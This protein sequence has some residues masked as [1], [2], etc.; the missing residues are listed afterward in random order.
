MCHSERPVAIIVRLGVQTATIGPAIV[1]GAV[2]VA[3]LADAGDRDLLAVEIRNNNTMM[4]AVGDEQAIAGSVGQ[5]FAGEEQRTFAGFLRAAAT[6]KLLRDANAAP[7]QPV[8]ALT[9]LAGAILGLLVCATGLLAVLGEICCLTT[10][11]IVLPA[12]LISLRKRRDERT[13]AAE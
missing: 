10:A 13:V 5:Y 8:T 7:G 6:N 3:G 2:L 11:V 12:F 9:Y 1:G 4:R